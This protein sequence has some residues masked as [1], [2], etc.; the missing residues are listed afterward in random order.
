MRVCMRVGVQVRMCACVCVNNTS[1][2]KS[3]ENFAE[4]IFKIFVDIICGIVYHVIVR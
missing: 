1:G 2:G 4:K 3:Q